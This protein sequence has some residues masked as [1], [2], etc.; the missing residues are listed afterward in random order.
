M[1]GVVSVYPQSQ[2]TSGENSTPV[3]TGGSLAR[4]HPV[5][6]PALV[7]TSSGMVSVT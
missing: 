5:P 7:Y 6:V 3:R 2:F 1:P 4:L